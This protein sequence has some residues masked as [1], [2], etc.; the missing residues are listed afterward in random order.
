LC[1]SIVSNNCPAHQSSCWIASQRNPHDDDSVAAVAQLHL[2][3][4]RSLA[5]RGFV[6]DLFLVADPVA[7]MMK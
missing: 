1:R 7:R 5:A 3:Q 6:P 2:E 4:I